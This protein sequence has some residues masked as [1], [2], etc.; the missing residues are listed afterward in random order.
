MLLLQ[1]YICGFKTPSEKTVKIE[2][3]QP[4]DYGIMVH[5]LL[6][7]S[8]HLCFYAKLSFSCVTFLS[9]IQ[10]TAKAPDRN[11]FTGL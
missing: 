6:L 10:K 11:Q 3:K 2:K 9:L 5:F 4:L 1:G 8:V 7:L